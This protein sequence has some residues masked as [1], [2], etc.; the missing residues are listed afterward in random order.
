MSQFTAPLLVSP[1][2]DGRTWVIITDD[3]QYDVGSEG[4]GD[5]VKIPQWMVTDFAS[6]PRPVWWFAAP[7]GR[8]GHAAVVHDAGYYL[9]D[10]SRAAYDRI[11]LEA[12]EVLGVQKF[13]RRVMYLAVRWFGGFAWRA[14]ARRTGERPGWKIVDPA[15]LGLSRAASPSDGTIQHEREEAPNV[16][17]SRQAVEAERKV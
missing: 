14:T 11:F 13:K 15:E 1:L 12:M 4:S 17:E 3:F 16:H 10:R 9:Q 8:H 6:I 2:D 7:W 5:T